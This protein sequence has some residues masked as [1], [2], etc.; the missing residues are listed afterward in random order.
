M[1]ILRQHLLPSVVPTFPTHLYLMKCLALTPQTHTT[2]SH[3]EMVHILAQKCWS[4]FFGPWTAPP[5]NNNPRSWYV[6]TT[7]PP[8]SLGR[9]RVGKL[10]CVFVSS[11]GVRVANIDLAL[12]RIFYPSSPLAL[13]ATVVNAHHHECSVMY[14]SVKGL[15]TCDFYYGMS[16]LLQLELAAHWITPQARAYQLQ[17]ASTT[18]VVMKPTLGVW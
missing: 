2:R 4:S 10:G 15:L 1:E 12:R 14:A 3:M 9:A 18:H 17:S 13:E 5:G 16:W 8:K 6:F 7:A 11:F